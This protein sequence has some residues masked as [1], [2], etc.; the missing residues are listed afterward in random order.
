MLRTLGVTRNEHP[1]R[2]IGMVY[3]Q[4]P[5]SEETL[6]HARTVAFCVLV[7]SQLFAAFAARSRFRTLWQLGL[8]TNR[9]LFGAV[10][11]SALLQLSIIALPLTR[12]VF[13]ATSHWVWGMGR[14]HP[15]RPD[16]G[17]LH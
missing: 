7:Y 10:A 15:S 6:A 14:H 9:Y 11:I 4:N 8:F 12:P 3:L 13:A 1:G 17:H 5:G 16:S 2:Y